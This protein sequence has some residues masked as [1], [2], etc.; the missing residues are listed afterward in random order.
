MPN[1][2]VIVSEF[3]K[4]GVL[5]AN[6]TVFKV[7]HLHGIRPFPSDAQ[8]HVLQKELTQRVAP[9]VDNETPYCLFRQRDDPFCL[10]CGDFV[11]RILYP[12]ATPLVPKLP[13]DFVRQLGVGYTTDDL[14]MY[15]VGLHN[16]PNKQAKLAQLAALDLP[17]GMRADITTMIHDSEPDAPAATAVAATPDTK[18][19]A[20]KASPEKPATSKIASRRQQNKKL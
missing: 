13:A 19:P 6:G 9:W 8:M 18:T 4:N 17:A 11:V 15:L 7:E 14:L 3:I 1:A 12:G 5:N 2:G 20:A 10:S 16:L